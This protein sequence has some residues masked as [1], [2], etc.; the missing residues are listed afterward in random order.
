[1]RMRILAF[2]LTAM[3]LFT[4]A[5]WALPWNIE[6][7]L[8]PAKSWYLV[9]YHSGEVLAEHNPDERLAPASLT[10]L[11][12]AYLVFQ[13]LRA[14]RLKLDDEIPVS[15]KA[16][17]MPGSRMFIRADTTVRAEDLI[18]GMLIES[19]N[20]AAVALAEHVAGNEQRFVALMNAQAAALGMDN[21]HYSDAT[22][23]PHSDH[24]STAR[25]L[26]VIARA[27]IRDF[28]E[29][30]TRWDSQKEF[31]YGGITQFNRNT[32]LWREQGV[33][34]MKTGYTRA[35]GYCLVASGM[36]DGMRLVV[37]L[38]GADSGHAR[39]EAGKEL[40]DFGFQQFETH[41][42]YGANTPALNVHVWMGAS[43]TLPAG[44]GHNL[45]LT[46]PRGTYDKLK[47][48]FTVPQV[49]I[50]PVRRGQ[51]IGT[52]T[53]NFDQTPLAQYPLV[54]LR[55]IGSGNLLQRARDRLRMWLH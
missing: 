55:H 51:T 35:A 17:R 13:E 29:Y 16:W 3:M 50:A 28:P 19:G 14:G 26:S 45:Y 8:V 27:I 38:L 48:Q 11:M 41:L 21:T 44:I 40:L 10:K 9:D 15:N 53:L 32:L 52:M 1:M 46:I 37:T 34:G 36:R 18:K 4:P 39:T 31:S 6:A 47:A 30:Y 12:T 22:G 43:D 2:S 23:L 33:D 5:A 20:D 49:Q 24:Y 54:A 42:L 7:P 25:D